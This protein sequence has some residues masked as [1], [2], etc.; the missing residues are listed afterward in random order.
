MEKDAAVKSDHMAAQADQSYF[1]GLVV[2]WPF[3]YNYYMPVFFWLLQARSSRL[4]WS[5]SCTTLL[6]SMRYSRLYNLPIST[7]CLRGNELGG[8]TGQVPHIGRHPYR[9][10]G[11]ILESSRGKRKEK[12]KLNVFT[13]N[14]TTSEIFFYW[15]NIIIWCEVAVSDVAMSDNHET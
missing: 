8:T 14:F 4:C 10:H 3:R 12:K 5:S 1:V 15:K 11:T 7:K 2:L 6:I 9:K 13:V